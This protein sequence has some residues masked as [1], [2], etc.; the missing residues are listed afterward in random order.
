LGKAGVELAA[1]RFAT[2]S[3]ENLLSRSTR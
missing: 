3:E 2:N 1:Y